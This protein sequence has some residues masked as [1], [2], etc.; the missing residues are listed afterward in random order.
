METMN[1]LL[2]KKMRTIGDDPQY[3][4]GYLNMMRHNIFSI[5]NHLA[6]KFDQALLRDEMNI[7]GSFLCNYEIKNVNWDH[8]FRHAVRF[9]PVIKIFNFEQLPASV[10]VH[11]ES[12]EKVPDQTMDFRKTCSTLGEV[13]KDLRDFRNDYTHY[14]STDK[15]A[16]RKIEVS[17]ATA[18]F[19]N[20]AFRLAIDYTKERMKDVLKEEDYKLVERKVMF[21]ADRHITTEGLVFLICMFLEREDAFR[22]IGKVKGL[23]GTQYSTFIA[24]REVLMA[25][26][27][28][29]PHDKFIN[30]D[31]K[32]DLTLNI[33]NEL[34]R[35]PKTL[36]HVIS[37]GDKKR[38]RPELDLDKKRKIIDSST[39]RD[40]TESWEEPDFE[41]YIEEITKQVRYEN[42]FSYFAMRFIDETNMFSSLRF[43]IDLGKLE[44]ASYNKM[45]AGE[46]VQRRVVENVKVFGKLSDYLQEATALSLI[47]NQSLSTGFVQFAPHYNAHNNRIGLSRRSKD[48]L[49]MKKEVLTNNIHLKLIQHQPD[50]FLS[51]HELPKII[52]LEYLQRGEAEKMIEWFID[53]NKKLL[54]RGFIEE[55]RLKLPDSWSDFRRRSAGNSK[56]GYSEK[57]L[58]ELQSRKQTL[59]VVLKEYGLDD[60]QIPARILNYWLKI[61]D[62]DTEHS[63]S[64][65][66]K[67]MRSDCKKRLRAME[68]HRLDPNVRVPKVGEMASFLAKDIV[69]MVIDIKKK[70]RITSFYYDKMQACLAFYADEEK[71]VLFGQIVKELGLLEKGGH[72]FLAKVLEGKPGNT[73]QLYTDYLK[74]KADKSMRKRLS[75]RMIEGPDTSWICRT[76]YRE[77]RCNGKIMTKIRL[78]EDVSE[79]P[80][81][82][83]QWA[84]KEKSD[85]DTWLNNITRR[86]TK[87]GID[88]PTNLFDTKLCELL[89]CRL[90]DKGIRYDAGSNYN[91]L[92]KLWWGLVRE[93][94][95]QEFYATEREY[96]VYGE[97]INFI[98]DSEKKFQNYYSDAFH[99]VAEQHKLDAVKQSPAQLERVFKH[100]VAGT[101]KEIRMLQEEDRLMLLMVEQLMGRM[102]GLK[103]SQ[104]QSLLD[105]EIPAELQL[106]YDAV[107]SVVTDDSA[108]SVMTRYVVATCKRK[109]HTKLRKYRYDRRLAGLFTYHPGEVVKQEW[110]KEQLA[111]YNK[112]KLDVF[113]MVFKLE[114]QI[115]LKDVDGVEALFLDEQQRPKSGNIQHWPYLKWLEMN[116]IINDKESH[117]LSSVRNSFSHNKFPEQE[118]MPKST[119]TENSLPIA[120]QIAN[121]YT[122]KVEEIMEK[123]AGL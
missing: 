29:L 88:L 76:F 25:Y 3:F 46:E 9:M 55:V 94:S 28:K 106:K 6:Q 73:A 53:I 115:I 54:T 27:V 39:D 19:L 101:E 17:P 67:L 81:T 109:D 114:E 84:A 30:E 7:A 2:E 120:A 1:A 90:D 87:K 121:A 108:V 60:K 116:G 59:N 105:E 34:N 52:L 33:I 77:E 62:V 45:L 21:D 66:I 118:D 63:F 80:L 49:L 100:A 111:A 75:K 86:E 23:K 72:P 97:N 16:L 18:D 24:T 74:E 14:F 95:V 40:D 85:L 10:R 37:E 99:K 107:G 5:S 15:G 68:K 98:A 91:E 35:C 92:L 104:V 11:E 47:D 79:I 78:P 8:I 58:E 65:R 71:N 64:E 117:F 26:C 89:R 82:I 123:V 38:F 56:T 50:V 61:V 22:F 42:R 32:Q 48:A 12:E 31:A 119:T 102:D 122:Q 110:L 113:D 4:G 20:D 70:E 57:A 83:N 112:A 69:S 13:F 43:Q 93:D 44:L 41:T 36:Y 96:V 51:L 103:L